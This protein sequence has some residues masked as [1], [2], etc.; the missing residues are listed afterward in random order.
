M[1][2]KKSFC[3]VEG[4]WNGAMHAKWASGE[5]SLFIDTNKMGIVK[6]KVR[7]LDDQLECESRC[8]WRVVSQNLKLRNIEAATEAKCRLEDKQ[9]FDALERKQNEKQ[10]ETRLFHKD[11]EQWVYRKP[12]LKR[13]AS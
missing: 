6:K 3:F 1:L 5:K 11:G 9:R 10:W 4:E 2:D 12:L 8:L 13:L 7:K